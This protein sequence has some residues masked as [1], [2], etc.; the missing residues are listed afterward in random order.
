MIQQ[1][2]DY[3]LEIDNDKYNITKQLFTLIISQTN[4]ISDYAQC[5][6]F[7]RET[8]F[9]YQ[10]EVKEVTMFIK[11]RRDIIEL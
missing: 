5:R 9:K 6:K 7:V 2:L 10:K 11:R 8:L 3:Q 1:T 4:Y